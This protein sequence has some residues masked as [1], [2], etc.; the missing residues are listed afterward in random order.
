MN[1]AAVQQPDIITKSYNSSD[2]GDFT[3]YDSKPDLDAIK[4]LQDT[5]KELN[6]SV[7]DLPDYEPDDSHIEHVDSKTIEKMRTDIREANTLGQSID[8][9]NPSP[10]SIEKLKTKLNDI[11]NKNEYKPYLKGSDAQALQKIEKHQEKAEK[12]QD[13]NE[14]ISN[15]ESSIST[16]TSQSEEQK[17]AMEDARNKATEAAQKALDGAV[18]DLKN[19]KDRQPIEALIKAYESVNP[20]FDPKIHIPIIEEMHAMGAKFDP[21]QRAVVIEDTDKGVKAVAT[22]GE[23]NI[24]SANGEEISEEMVLT[25]VRDAILC[26]HDSIEVEKATPAQLAMIQNGAQKHGIKVIDLTAQA[27]V[28][29]EQKVDTT[30]SAPKISQAPVKEAPTA[31]ASPKQEEQAVEKTP[32]AET[33]TEK[34]APVAKVEEEMPAEDTVNVDD[35]NFDDN[36]K[37]LQNG[38]AENKKDTT[39]QKSEESFLKKIF[40]PFIGSKNSLSA[41]EKATL[42]VYKEKFEDID[43]HIDKETKKVFASKARYQILCDHEKFMDKKIEFK[44]SQVYDLTDS[45]KGKVTEK[46]LLQRSVEKHD[47][48]EIFDNVALEMKRNAETQ[49][50]LDKGIHNILHPH[51]IFLHNEQLLCIFGHK[52]AFR[53]EPKITIED[54]EFLSPTNAFISLSL[55]KNELIK[56]HSSK[57]NAY[58]EKRIKKAVTGNSR[59]D[60]ISIT[61]TRTDINTAKK[62]QEFL[63]EADLISEQRERVRVKFDPNDSEYGKTPLGN[64]AINIIES[65]NQKIPKSTLAKGYKYQ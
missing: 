46:T 51:G 17:A 6:I 8:L 10:E 25:C 41:S 29:V 9:N 62:Y 42:K 7:I 39:E 30:A 65:I 21:D 33:E 26:G 16:K 13:L 18:Q 28:T 31:A 64:D 22:F 35:V 2:F 11:K 58:L 53:D 4:E 1:Q 32:V 63:S 54:E 61:E 20:N 24:Y 59:G 57:T 15:L 3:P 37:A 40:K 23:V 36:N 60:T 38:V 45:S 47:T 34:Q 49:Q 14:K 27:N 5:L 52:V 43:N 56:E 55:K 12:I 50:P 44:P 48:I 19:Q